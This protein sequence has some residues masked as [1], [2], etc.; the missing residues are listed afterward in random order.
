MAEFVTDDLDFSAFEQAAEHRQKVLPASAFVDRVVQRMLRPEGNKGFGLPWANTLE[1]FRLRPNELTLWPG[2]N[3][4]GKA[5]AIDTP[6]PTPAGWKTMGAMQVGDVVFDERGNPCRVVATSGVMR[7][8]PCYRVRFSDGAAIVADAQHEWL[9]DTTQSRHSERQEKVRAP[10][11]QGLARAN[12]Q[13][14]RA[15]AAIRTTEQIAKTLRVQDGCWRGLLEHSV[16]VCGAIELPERTLPIDPYLLGCWLGDGHSSS[17]TMTSADEE[18]IQAFVVGG[19]AVLRRKA[20]YQH[21]ITGGFQSALRSLGVLNNKHIPSWYLRASYAQRLA[22]VQGLMDTDGSATS[23]GRCEFTSTNRGLADG[24]LELILSLG[25]QARMIFGTATLYG[26]DCGPKYRV[27]FTPHLP[28]FRLSRK[29]TRLKSEVQVRIKARF[30]VECAPVDSVPVQC[31]QVDSPS[32]LY[33]ASQSFIPT[34]NSLL[35]S[36]VMVQ[37]M[38]HGQKVFIASLEMRPEWTLERMTRQGIGKRRGSE[39]EIRAFHRWTDGKLWL[40]DHVGAVQ[41]R[42]LMAVCRWVIAEKKVD[43]IVID[44]LMRLGVGEQDYDGQKAV[45]D[46]LCDLRHDHAVHIHLVMH[47]RKLADEF[48]PP[49]KFDA[50][51]TGTI[52]DLADNVV[53][54]WRNKKKESFPEKHA[55]DPDALLICD[56]QRNGEWEGK[57]RLWFDKDSMQ[58]LADPH[59]DRQ[60]FVHLPLH[61]KPQEVC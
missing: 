59:G 25:I 6:I 3:G 15:F 31:I 29:L 2:I 17:A 32:H 20:A 38:D 40:Y 33:L 53:T 45:V 19:Y 30:I 35:L 42:K 23:Y 36:H 34:H 9:T 26:K 55:D 22:L 21:G 37:C 16:P 1:Q 43:H 51:G 52:T 44:S 39:E 46:A 11:R 14:K 60:V 49:G 57:V 48:S 28:V 27:T 12:Q 7:G 54:V 61:V 10:S 13:H 56:K 50:K 5:L 8:R 4:H 58:Y 47:S 24:L 18:V 41:W